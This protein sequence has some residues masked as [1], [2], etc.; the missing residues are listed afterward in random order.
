MLIG[1][2]FH[3]SCVFG[4][5]PIVLRDTLSVIY[6]VLF[7]FTLFVDPVNMTC[8]ELLIVFFNLGI[9]LLVLFGYLKLYL[10]DYGFSLIL[11]AGSGV[12]LMDAS[13][14]VCEDCSSICCLYRICVVSFELGS[15]SSSSSVCNWI[16]VSMSCSCSYLALASP[17]LAN[18]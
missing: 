14:W 3:T 9:V 13:R 12:F 6:L 18:L 17:W 15:S 8:E 2:V 16:L 1:F 4:V 5:T 11:M 10:Y 7:D